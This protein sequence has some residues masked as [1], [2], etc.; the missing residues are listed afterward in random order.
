MLA[1]TVTRAAVTDL[2]F[3]VANPVSLTGAESARKTQF[4]AWGYTVTLINDGDTQTAFN[5]AT[6]ANNVAYVSPAVSAAALGTK[7]KS[8]SIGVV[9][10]RSDL[11]VEF[12]FSSSSLSTTTRTNLRIQTTA[13]NL[14]YGLS[15][16]SVT[17]LNS[18]Q[19][20]VRRTGTLASG[21]INLANVGDYDNN[22]PGL[23]AIEVG[24]GLYGGGVAA[25]RRVLLPFGSSTFSYAALNSNGLQI[26]ERALE[27]AARPNPSIGNV[28]LVVTSTSSP[29]LQELLREG[30]IHVWGYDVTRIDDDASQASYTAALAGKNAVYVT[31][32]SHST[33]LGTKLTGATIG[34]VNEEMAFTD[35]L[36]VSTSSATPYATGV[37]ITDNSHY[38]T[39]PFSTGALTLFTSSQEALTLAGTLAPGLQTLATVG[40]TQA[41]A[42]VETGG[43]LSSGATALGRR[44]QLPWGGGNLDQHAFHRNAKT[45]MRRALEWAAAAPGPPLLMVVANNGSLSAQESARKTLLE[46]WGYRVNTLDDDANTASFNAAVAAN[47][48]VY[49][50]VEINSAAL[51]TK[52]RDAAIGIVSEEVE[53][54]DEFGIASSQATGSGSQAT[55]AVNTH[56]ITSPF[57]TGALA[58]FDANQ[59]YAVVSGTIASDGKVLATWSGAKSLVALDSGGKMTGGGFAAG[60]RV[61]L[62]WGGASFSF[63]ALSN[64]GKTLLQRAL[65]W[66]GGLSGHWRLDETS[67]TTAADSS[68]KGNHGTLVGTTF[69]TGSVSPGKLGNA[70]QFNGSSRYITIPSASSLQPT[71]ALTIS[72]WINGTAWGSGTD[73]DAIL[74]KGEGNPNNYQL[75]VTNGRLTLYLDG[76]DGA[77]FQGNTVLQTGVWYHVAATWDGYEVRLYVNGD[78]D[79]AVAGVY[80]VGIGTDNRALYIGG[81]AG[82]DFFHGTIDDVRMLNYAAPPDEVNTFMKAGQAKGLRIVKWVEK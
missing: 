78:L 65:Q 26:V 52:L 46:S 50:P 75:A 76:N 4:E 71:G 43:V 16:G 47:Q 77:G 23:L 79:Q 21:A 15:T 81:R 80:A 72:A 28:L 58:L 18:S 12:G 61:Q 49:L 59:D 13:H 32:E 38:I 24:G 36:G 2:L 35:E 62:P 45:I 60:R 10:E 8:T 6:A 22:D 7:L 27:W 44:V 17:I 34:V 82:Q 66:A 14:T 53:L 73:V 48:I 31:E 67:G 30:Q 74:R 5:T 29:T 39:A 3:V 19:T 41:L 42:V 25:G 9:N 56:Y 68:G 33:S 57:A 64:D 63:S 1:P 20:L 69:A 37:T 11:A 55:I 54:S 51:G 70:L 40:G